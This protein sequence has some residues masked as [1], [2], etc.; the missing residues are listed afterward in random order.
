M[1]SWAGHNGKQVW[2]LL[3]LLNMQTVMMGTHFLFFLILIISKMLEI[4]GVY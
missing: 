4:R 1:E 3:V 2:Y